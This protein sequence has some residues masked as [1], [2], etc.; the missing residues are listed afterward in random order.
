MAYDYF[1]ADW[2]GLCDD[3]RDVSWEDIFKLSTSATAAA[4]EFCEWVQVEIDVHIPH[5]MYQVKIHSSPWFS[6]AC[7]GAIV[8]RNHS[9]HLYQQNKSSESKVKFRQASNH[10]KRVLEATKLA[11]LLKQKNPSLPRNFALGT[12]GELLIVFSTKINL[13]YLI[14]S[15]VQCVAFCI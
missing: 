6:T 3:L 7:A 2:D 15:V 9:F 14:Y 11:M 10:C 8:H 4:G 13:Q 12:F 1:H 5:H